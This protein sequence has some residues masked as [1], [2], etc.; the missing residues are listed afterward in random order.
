MISKSTT[1]YIS[2]HLYEATNVNGIKA[3]VDMRPSEEK[4][5]Q[6]PVELLISALAACVAVEVET[7]IKKKRKT[8]TKL[9]IESEYNRKDTDPKGVTDVHQKYM[10]TSPDVKEE[11]LTKM[12]NM[13]IEGYCS[14]ADSLKAT[15]TFGVEIK[16][17]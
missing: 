15:I 10:L 8:F 16:A 14:V 3:L 5:N 6:G 4:Q 12:I 11:E 9:V 1:K 2:D 13:I 7:I 17:A